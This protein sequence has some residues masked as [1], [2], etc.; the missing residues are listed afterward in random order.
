MLV[1]NVDILVK[2]AHTP[3][4]AEIREILVELVNSAIEAGNPSSSMRKWVK[5]EAGK[6]KVG[7]YEISL[8]EARRIVVVGGG[9]ADAAMAIT[10]EQILGDR[11][12]EGIVNIPEG[13]VPKN[14]A[15]KIK[16]VEAG[17][18]IPSESGVEGARQMLDLVSGLGPRDVVI[19]LISG[20]GSALMPLPAEGIELSELQEVTQLLLKSGATIQ[21]FNATRKH[22]S[23][24]KGGQLARAACPARIITLIISDVIGDRLDTIASGPACWDLTTYRD[25]FSVLE[26]YELTEKVPTSVMTRLRDGVKGILPETPKVGEECFQN[27]CYRIIASNVDA[28]KMAA[29]VGKAHDLNIHVLT[30]AM[31]GEARQVGADLARVAKEI[32]QTGKPIPV[33]ALLLSGGETTVT[34]R[35][36]GAGGRNQE[37]ALSA[38]LGLAGLENAAIVSFGTDGIDGP[39]DAAGAVAD[40]F[41]LQRAGEIGLDICAYLENNDSYHFFKELGDLVMTGPSGT[42]IMDVTALIISN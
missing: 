41:T 3:R 39:T 21:E 22:L 10:L 32:C 30:A 26:K 34:V 29:E 31:Q 14:V 35:G 28:L 16:F 4:L 12:T 19:C 18:P 27:A 23:A 37:L 11:L 36:K 17:H 1:K 25:A 20:G 9:K 13:T 24:F 7:N 8:N 15:H 42:N 5:F 38:A 40:G 33:P 6:L 2:N